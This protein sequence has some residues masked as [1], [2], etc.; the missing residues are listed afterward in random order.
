MEAGRVLLADDMGLGKTIQAIAAIELFHKYLDVNKVLIICPTSLKYQWKS[1]IQKFTGRYSLIIEGL[2]HKRKELYSEKD[3]IKII[4]YGA[5]RNDSEFINNWRPDLMIID[6]AQ[7]IKNW[8]TQTARSVKKIQSEYL[9]VLTGTPLENRIDEIHSIVEY[10]DRYR[11]GQKNILTCS[12]LFQ[13]AQLNTGYCIY[14]VL[15]NLFLPGLLR[16]KGR[17]KLCLKVSWSQ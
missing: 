2:I 9:I 14:L 16:M 17:M 5:G 13:K 11:L 7:R 1:E 15:R 3:F 8:K 10:I 6:E 4:S 12:I